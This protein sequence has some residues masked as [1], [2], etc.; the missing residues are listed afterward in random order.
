MEWIIYIGIVIGVLM[1]ILPIYGVW[2]SRKSGEAEL[3]EAENA[4]K[5]A[6]MKANARLSSAK[7]NKEAEIIEAEAVSMSIKE[8]GEA[9]EKNP[10][11]NRW[12]WIK[13]M[14]RDNNKSVIY[15]PTETNIPILEATRIE[16]PVKIEIKKEN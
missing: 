16:R 12:Q 7:A 4:E 1:W 6:I 3:A 8:I 5:V 11:Y 2:T 13:M 9:L 14:D 15:V 10:S